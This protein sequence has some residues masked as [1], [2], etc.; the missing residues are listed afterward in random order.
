MRVEQGMKAEPSIEIGGF[1]P[2]CL[3]E[4]LNISVDTKPEEPVKELKLDWNY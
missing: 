1:Y 2:P 4:K 3:K